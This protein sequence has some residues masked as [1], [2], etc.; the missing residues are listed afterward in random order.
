[1]LSKP[2]HGAAPSVH[3]QVP[4]DKRPPDN[5]GNCRPRSREGSSEHEPHRGGRALMDEWV[6]FLAGT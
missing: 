1:M 3:D 6:T 4:G 5:A 2:S